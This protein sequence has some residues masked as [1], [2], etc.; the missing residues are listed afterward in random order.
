MKKLAAACSSISAFGAAT[1]SAAVWAADPNTAISLPY[2]T[3][4]SSY[5]A[6][7]SGT[8][9]DIRTVG[10]AGATVGLGDTF[11]AAGDNPAGLALTMNVGDTH[12]SAS[13]I[14]DRAVQRSDAPTVSSSFGAAL[15]AGN[16]GFSLGSVTPWEEGQFFKI[17][18]QVDPY[19]LDQYIREYRGGIARR[20]DSLGLAVGAQLRWS[21]LH[22]SIGKSPSEFENPD[23]TTHGTGVT[24]GAL[25]RLPFHML[26]GAAYSTPIH[27]NPGIG[28]PS[29]N[30][31]PGYLQPVDSP[32]KISLGLGFIPNRIF[33]ADFT[34]QWVDETLGASVLAEEGLLAGSHDTLEPR[35]GAAYVFGDFRAMRATAFAGTYLEASRVRLAP[36][37]LHATGG[38][39]LKWS[40]V[41][42]GLGLDVAKGYQNRMASIGI[43]PF[44]VMEKLGLIPRP[45]AH[46][47]R[48]A[49]STFLYQSDEGLPDGLMDA[50]RPSSGGPGIDPIQIGTDIPRILGEKVRTLSPI[51]VIET[52]RELPSEI[53]ADLQEVGRE[54]QRSFRDR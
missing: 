3:R 2:S 51:Q 42:F 19:H 49:L 6:Y 46:R 37:R 20:W 47:P 50:T 9:G 4:N 41:N 30:V 21:V 16:W 1:V 14:S 45:P 53:G 18:G 34:L 24:L 8:R 25:Y 13:E 32:T 31:L 36:T 54:I 12:A 35:V 17:P 10:M 22:Q 44:T 38:M 39:E 26:L 52:I 11:A 43:D 27:F 48:G 5:S 7:Q 40:F 28:D 23:E 15:Q 33:R 29:F